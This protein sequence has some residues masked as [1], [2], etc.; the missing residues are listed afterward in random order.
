MP[1]V[2]LVNFEP[3]YSRYFMDEGLNTPDVST[4]SGSNINRSLR[5]EY[6]ATFLS[7]AFLELDPGCTADEIM[8]EGDQVTHQV[9]SQDRDRLPAKGK[10]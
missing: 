5:A 10:R 3:T 9:A 6:F 2:F 7:S 1:L 4:A 8:P